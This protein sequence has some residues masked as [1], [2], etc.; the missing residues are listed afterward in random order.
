ML[1][2]KMSRSMFSKR[3]M[4]FSTPRSHILPPGFG[5]T[6][7]IRR[8]DRWSTLTRQ[9]PMHPHYTTRHCAAFLTWLR[10]SPPCVH[11]RSIV[12]MKAAEL[13]YTRRCM[14]ATQTSHSF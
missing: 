9:L 2:S 12:E 6:T 3:Y 10:V 11:R 7:W 4:I 13:L 5:Y 8:G 1:G 14:E